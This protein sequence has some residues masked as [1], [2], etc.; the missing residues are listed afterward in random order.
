MAVC[1]RDATQHFPQLAEEASDGNKANDLEAERA[2]SSHH[3]E[4]SCSEGQEQ[5]RAGR[6]DRDQCVQAS[7]AAEQQQ[8]QQEGRSGEIGDGTART[9]QQQQQQQLDGTHSFGCAASQAGSQQSGRG[10]RPACTPFRSGGREGRGREDEVQGARPG[11]DARR[12]VTALHAFHA[13]VIRD[14]F[15]LDN[16]E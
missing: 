13:R 7:A 8:G 10:C 9:Q 4:D 2:G 11:P 6:G 12:A 1:Q 3:R 5:S 15:P 16:C 14:R